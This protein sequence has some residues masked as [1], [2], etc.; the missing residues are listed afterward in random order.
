[1]EVTML[2]RYTDA[3]M[4]V[5]DMRDDGFPTANTRIEVK[6]LLKEYFVEENVARTRVVAE[7]YL[8]VEESIN[9]IERGESL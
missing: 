2:E 7:S 4:N 9:K 3:I 5:I 8:D 1:M 6:R